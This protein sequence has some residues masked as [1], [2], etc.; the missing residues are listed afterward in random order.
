LSAIVTYRPAASLILEWTA[1]SEDI[2]ISGLRGI[3]IATG[4]NFF[5]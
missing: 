1:D 4:I 2:H 3:G 5:E